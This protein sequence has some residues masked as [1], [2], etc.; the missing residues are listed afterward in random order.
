[1]C[2]PLSCC[3]S[4][5]RPFGPVRRQL[6]CLVRLLLASGRD[7]VP[8]T[9]QADMEVRLS[10]LWD[11]LYTAMRQYYR[12]P[13]SRAEELT[14][15]VVHTLLRETCCRQ[16]VRE[17][18]PLEEALGLATT[19]RVPERAPARPLIPFQFPRL[20]PA[21]PTGNVPYDSLRLARLR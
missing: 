5:G 19:P 3:H 15:Q 16:S 14:G 12:V 6:Y 1:M 4:Q 2:P 20:W 18:I 10:T 8:A 13:Q 11:C 21:Q 9:Q 17:A 7:E